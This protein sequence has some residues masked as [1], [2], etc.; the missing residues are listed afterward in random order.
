MHLSPD[1]QRIAYRSRETGQLEVFV[2]SFPTGGA[3]PV[4]VSHG[5]GDGPRWSAD[6]RELFFIAGGR[7]MAVAV[8]QGSSVSLGSASPLFALASANYAVH[9]DGTRFLVQV[10]TTPVSSSV[11]IT[12]NLTSR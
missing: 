11:R 3:H 7:L 5:G 6:S 10:P 8:A 2:D 1:G 4:Q 9:P 12:L